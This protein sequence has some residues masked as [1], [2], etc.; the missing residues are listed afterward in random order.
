M[1]QKLML[2]MY[3]SMVL[4]NQFEA[5]MIRLFQDGRVPGFTHSCQGQEAVPVGVCSALK[6]TDR[7]GATHR[8]H[9]HI[10]AKGANPR[11]MMAEILGRV[12]GYCKGMSGELH[13]VDSSV[14]V[15]G[16]N[17]IVGAGIPILTGAALADQL[18]DNGRVS[19]SFFGDGA[20]SEGTFAESLNIATNWKLPV[21]FVCEN[22]HYAEYSAASDTVAG[23]IWRRAEA[24]G[25]PGI[26]VDG[27]VVG[28][29][30][31]VAVA[32][33][34][35]ARQGEGPSLIEADTYRWHGHVYGEDA[36]IGSYRYRDR[37]E[38]KRMRAERDPIK[39]HRAVCIDAGVS[40]D[41]LTKIDTEVRAEVDDAVE[42]ALAS[43]LPAPE[44]ALEFLFA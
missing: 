25:I 9:G 34:T 43:P 3:R 39:L 4:I 33:V 26:R 2:K 19:V 40:G 14:G 5:A 1:E 24:Y 38:V 21:I 28:D 32:A 42:F 6:E 30:Y 35:R 20:T 16:A 31:E 37:D 36:L 12:D 22:N 10:L 11:P 18:A 23:E 7:I 13:I 27:Q 8:G 41:D 15:V 29:V 17:G 44:Q